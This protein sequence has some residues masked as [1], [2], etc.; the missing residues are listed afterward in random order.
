MLGQLQGR[1]EF[2]GRVANIPRGAKFSCSKITL[3]P[4]WLTPFRNLR[5]PGAFAGKTE[6]AIVLRYISIQ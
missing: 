1:D 3:V 5:S 6:D 4:A 2:Q